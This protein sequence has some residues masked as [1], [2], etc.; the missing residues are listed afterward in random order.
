MA[1]SDNVH[2]FHISRIKLTKMV[3]YS[4]KSVRSPDI[5][6]AK[7]NFFS[8]NAIANSRVTEAIAPTEIPI[9]SHKRYNS[10]KMYACLPSIV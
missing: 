4:R 8:Y 10:L 6:S 5:F 7:L 3:S 9:P 1:L 2:S